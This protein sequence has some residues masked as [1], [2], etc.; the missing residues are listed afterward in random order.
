MLCLVAQSCPIL[1]SPVDCSHPGSTVHGILQERILE[2]VAMPSSRGSSQPRGSNLGLP[3]CRRI[4]YHLSYQGSPRILEWAAYPFSRGSS[5]PR[6]Q[7]GV[8]Y[9]AGRFF[10]SKATQEAPT[11]AIIRIKSCWSTIATLFM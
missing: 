4:L 9:I 8:S 5:Q 7:S 10:I 11:L 6:N 1:C 2:W 3:H